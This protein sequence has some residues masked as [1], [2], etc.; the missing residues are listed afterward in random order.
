MNL[1]AAQHLHDHS[2]RNFLH[3]QKNHHRNFLGHNR[4]RNRLGHN[5]YRNRLGQHSHH[6]VPNLNRNHLG[7]H[8]LAHLGQSFLG[9]HQCLVH[10]VHILLQDCAYLY[11]PFFF[12]YE[13]LCVLDVLLAVHYAFLDVVLFLKPCDQCD[14]QPLPILL[15]YALIHVQVCVLCAFLDDQQHV[16]RVLLDLDHELRKIHRM[17]LQK[18]LKN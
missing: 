1:V 15:H 6:L 13:R 18:L 5:R 7:Q 14:F 10:F 8:P 16:S 9:P 3:H 17:L 4:Y 11:A 2:Q 12:Q